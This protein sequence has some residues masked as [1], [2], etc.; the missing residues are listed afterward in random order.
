MAT[1]R[2]GDPRIGMAVFAYQQ[3][4]RSVPSVLQPEEHGPLTLDEIDKAAA[5]MTRIRD[6]IKAERE[7]DL[8]TEVL[9]GPQ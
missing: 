7:G 8:S 9:Q 6:E 2:R 5:L 3:I 1:G 4:I